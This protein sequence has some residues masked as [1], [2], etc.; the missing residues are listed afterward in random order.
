MEDTHFIT[1]SEIEFFFCMIAM[2]VPKLFFIC[3]YVFLSNSCIHR[4]FWGDF[5]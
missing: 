1:E 4:N 2:I 3:V 5:L